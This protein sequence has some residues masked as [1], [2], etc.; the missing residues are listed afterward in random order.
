MN[1]RSNAYQQQQNYQKY[2]NY[3]NALRNT[4]MIQHLTNELNHK[5]SVIDS[6]D[7]EIKEKHKEM[8]E[9]NAVI[10]NKI[11]LLEEIGSV[12]V[13][14]NAHLEQLQHELGTKQQKID[15]LTGLHDSAM[16]T[17]TK[18]ELEI[19][20]MHEQVNLA[21]ND[22]VIRRTSRLQSV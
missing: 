21:H 16:Q 11:K 6:K 5:I 12:I 8:A 17:V 22:Y 18:L 13:K 14:N 20:R 1:N 2:Q 7:N 10:Q 9:M 15:E 3:Q 19:A 4:N